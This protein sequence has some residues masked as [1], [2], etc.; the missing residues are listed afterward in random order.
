MSSALSSNSS[1]HTGAV[2][3]Y[4]VPACSTTSTGCWDI[5][6]SWALES[7]ASIFDEMAPCGASFREGVFSCL[8]GGNCMES[9][10]CRNSFSPCSPSSL[11][12]SLLSTSNDLAVR[13]VSLFKS[14]MI[15]S[16]ARDVFRMASNV[17]ASLS[18]EGNPPMEPPS[19]SLQLSSHIAS[20]TVSGSIY[21]K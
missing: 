18:L 11:P 6:S 15:P 21:Y 10:S 17:R 2:S 9:S 19:V 4:S 3:G 14:R 16:S 1:E 5:L 7:V 13:D 12:L 20:L 8:N